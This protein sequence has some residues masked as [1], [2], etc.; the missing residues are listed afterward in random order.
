MK[1]WS[2]NWDAVWDNINLRASIKEAIVNFA[3][4]TNNLDLLEAPFVIQSN[5]QFHKISDKVKE[6]IGTLDSKRIFFEWNEWLK[7]HLKKQEIVEA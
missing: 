4:S 3:V 1:D 7:R 2:G 6:D 5:D